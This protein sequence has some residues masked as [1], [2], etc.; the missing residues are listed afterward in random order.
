[1]FNIGDMMARWT[2]DQYRST[3]H[4]VINKDPTR[5]RY[6]IPAF[7]DPNLKANIACLP[8]FATPQQPAQFPPI[9]F[10]D[11]YA[12]RLDSNYKF[13]KVAAAGLIG[14]V[15]DFP[16]ENLPVLPCLRTFSENQMR[17]G[18]AEDRLPVRWADAK[19]D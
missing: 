9:R 17:N 5:D 19:D 13:D 6:S 12:G 10:G 16:T 8:A 15:S 3:R 18:S 2:N 1:V 14:G 4:R 11:Y 7:F